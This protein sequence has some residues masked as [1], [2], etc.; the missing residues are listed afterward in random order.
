MAGD[1]YDD[2]ELRSEDD[3]PDT[4]TFDRPGDR[5]RGEVIRVDRADLPFGPVLKYSILE[6]RSRREV[7]LLAG[8][9][10]LKGQLLKLRPR[11]GDI[12]DVELVELR[13]T[14]AGSNPAKLF[15]VQVTPAGRSTTSDRRRDDYYEERERRARPEPGRRAPAPR[16]EEP[17]P[18]DEGDMFDR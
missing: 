11:P 16:D 12:L 10:N 17:F 9:K 14:G 8:P 18:M 4:V 6:E 13:R 1:V 3:Y 2:P 7:Q 15:D 5:V